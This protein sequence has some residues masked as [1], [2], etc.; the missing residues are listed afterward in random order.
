M[1]KKQ[2]YKYGIGKR[3]AASARIHLF[4][5]KGES[6]VNGIPLPKYFSGE[7]NKTVWSKPFVLTQTLEKY[8]V[9]AKITGGGKIGQLEAFVQGVAK[10]L[11]DENPEKFKTALKKAGLLTRDARGRERR[12]VGMGGKSRRVKQSPKR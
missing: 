11:V 3:R 2:N 4:K 1:A 5:G 8:Y 7:V 9:T 6:L 12:K 10:A